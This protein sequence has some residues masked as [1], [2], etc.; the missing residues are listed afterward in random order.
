ML[1]SAVVR[2]AG[3][4][5]VPA[6]AGLALSFAALFFANGLADAPLV[7]I[8]G[9]ALLAAAVAVAWTPAPGGAALAYV[10]CLFGLAVWSGLTILWSVSPD[11][12]W[13]FTNR[14]LVYAG[15][16]ALGVV[17]GDRERVTPA[18]TALVA[19]VVGYALLAKAIPALYDDYGR[20]ARLRAP[21]DDWNMLALVCAAGTPLALWLAS[22]RR[23]LGTV[24]L[25]LA[26]VTL[27]LTYSRFGVLL[28]IAAAGV[29][30][31]RDRGALVP[32]AI[33]GGTA[34][35]TFGIALALNGITDD[36]QSHSS[37]VRDGVLFLLVLSAGSAACAAA[38][39][40]RGLERVAAAA[41][42]ALVVAGIAVTAVKA[43][44]IWT[45]FT[46]TQAQVGNEAGRFGT[47]ASGGRW[48]WWQEAWR[49]F[50]DEPLGGTGAGTFQFTDLRYRQ[51]S[52]IRATEPHNTPLQFLSETGI[53][54]LL[55]FLGA[56]GIVLWRG[57]G[58]LAIAFA[59]FAAHSLVNYD[60]SF[61]GVTGPFLLVGGV[62]V[63]RPRGDAAPV[64]RLL[65]AAAAVAFALASVYSLA[66]PWLAERAY[67][68]GDYEQAHSYNPLSPDPLAARAELVGGVQGE[69]L[70]RDAV[71]LEPQNAALWFDFARF[72]AEN[73]NWAFAYRALS[74][75]YE[76]DPKGDAAQCGLAQQ[77]RRKVGIRTSCRGAG[78]PSIP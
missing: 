52:D 73:G 48:S 28:A 67:L 14:T 77:I 13:T 49:G 50:T 44:N 51:S 16:A 9:L 37:R 26:L 58:P 56:V 34:A 31:V 63:A 15:F 24:L 4:R 60:W 69:A 7:W 29:W 39:R 23:S 36:A 33:A 12:S 64:R 71:A 8:G 1:A 2:A 38:A 42:V 11:R 35:A 55:L 21:L 57:R 41:A 45:A 18:A 47:A 74:K 20:V 68:R 10:G 5:A 53:V 32:L 61:L 6:L 3:V 76:Y 78:S 59:V 22:R 19:A 40:L 75:A 17:I 65:P 43:D 66:A 54:G 46:S 72:Y 27:L 30:V 62:L 70:F 25:Y